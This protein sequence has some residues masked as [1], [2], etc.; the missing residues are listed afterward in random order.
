MRQP[1]AYQSTKSLHMNTQNPFPQRP[2]SQDASRDATGPNNAFTSTAD[3]D[4]AF[5][6]PV[7]FQ[8]ITFTTGHS[9]CQ[10]R[11]A[12]PDEIAATLSKS[13]AEGLAKGGWTDLKRFGEAS[14]LHVSVSQT[15]LLAKLYLPCKVPQAAK[16]TIWIGISAGASAGTDAWK[17]LCSNAARVGSGVP[18][19]PPST[20]WIGVVLNE[21]L[22]LSTD[23]ITQLL[24]FGAMMQW[25]GDFERCLAW[26][27]VAWLESAR[28]ASTTR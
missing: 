13:I 27:F 1:D 18:A 15:T 24:A 4:S 6:A 22:I 19:T 12:V 3:V 26:G 17:F 16:P 7:S 28:S 2:T 14:A 9:C 8:H 25:A 23:D 10:L 11:D 5:A 20:P 21:S